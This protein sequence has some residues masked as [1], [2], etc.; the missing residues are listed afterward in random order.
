MH[1]RTN[2]AIIIACAAIMAACTGAEEKQWEATSDCANA[3]V[4]ADTLWQ[5]DKLDS[6]ALHY[7]NANDHASEMLIRQKLGTVM[8]NRSDFEAAVKQHDRCIELATGTKDTLQLIIAY[9]NQGTN[10][11]RIGDLEQASSYHYKALGL[12]DKIT[13][14]TSFIARKNIVRHSTAW[15][16]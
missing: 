9:N 6:I 11:R 12:C 13:G 7:C 14:D 16:M 1:T 4:I 3:K 10:F 15:E 2:T 8:R 5:P